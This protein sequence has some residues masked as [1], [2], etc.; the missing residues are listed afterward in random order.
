MEIFGIIWNEGLIRPMTNGLIIL[1]LSLFNNFGLAIITF[2]VIIRI[3]TIP[4]TL[5][6]L[7]SSKAMAAVQPKVL[8]LQKK[9]GNDRQKISQETFKL[10][11]ESG[12]NPLGCLGPMVVQMPIWIGLYWSLIRALPSNPES[13]A[14][15]AEV[16]YSNINFVHSAIPIQ[17]G[18][19]WLDLAKPDSTPI[20][21][22]CVGISM[23]IQQKMMTYPSSD[24]KQRQTNQIMLWMMPVMFVFFTF[25]FP[26][27]LALYWVVTNII[28]IVIQYFV[29]GWGNL[30][31]R[32][33]PNTP[34]TPEN[35]TSST[36]VT[37]SKETSS[38]TEPEDESKRRN[39]RNDRP[40]RR[41]GNRGRPNT[42]R[43]KQK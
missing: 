7:R 18:F 26:S 9:H 24:P 42:T 29:T 28:G 16:L 6:Q 22:L 34:E 13:L 39:R 30:L 17:S 41:R 43:R 4:L 15:L 35:D 8:A 12:V 14:G 5:K 1:Y 33:T 31:G 32:N 25:Q 2:T 38:E 20:L 27:G 23:W 3:L 40:V 11:R 21:P 10:Y 19:L 36:P 37:N